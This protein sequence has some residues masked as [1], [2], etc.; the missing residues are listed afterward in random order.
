MKVLPMTI[1]LIQEQWTPH[2]QALIDALREGGN[3]VTTWYQEPVNRVDP[4]LTREAMPKDD[5]R[6]YRRNSLD[7]DFL[8]Q[9]L[10]CGS[11]T[12]VVV[13]W[14]NKN[15]RA[16]NLLL[17][18]LFRKY[19]YWSDNPTPTNRKSMGALRWSLRK[20][21]L[22]LLRL[23]RGLVFAVGTSAENYF[24]SCGIPAS[25][26]VNVPVPPPRFR[27][28]ADI[29]F[30]AREMISQAGIQDSAPYLFAGSRL[31]KEK[32]FDVLIDAYEKL[33]ST[34]PHAPQLVI[35]GSGPE[36][37][38]LR[39]FAGKLSCAGKVYFVGWQPPEIFCQLVADA[40]IFI[41]PARF[42]AYGATI[43]AASLG[44]PIIGSDGAG[45]VVD[46]VED[47]ITGLVFRSGDARHLADQM[48][49]LIS[50][51]NLRLQIARNLTIEAGNWDAKAIARIFCA[52]LNDLSGNPSAPSHG[53][54]TI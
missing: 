14:S 51:Q 18:V 9:I 42:D 38:S 13:G 21:A 26:V 40:Q 53:Q 6:F 8:R 4:I 25:R 35:C 36:E 37:Q 22:K 48:G 12:P 5:M 44:V 30:R 3:R 2:N 43:I 1:L 33:N 17:Q 52:G 15:T 23:S 47:G 46:R 39:H 34:S 27:G 50:D 24:L 29:K 28:D 19:V 54:R 16:A 41:H 32:G 31:V 10:F 49:R 20:I 7:W 11:A 45:A